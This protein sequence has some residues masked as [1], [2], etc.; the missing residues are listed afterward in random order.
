MNFT[1]LYASGSGVECSVLKNM[2]SGS[3]RIWDTVLWTSWHQEASQYGTKC[4]ELHFSTG[5]SGS[6]VE[7]CELHVITD[8]RIW[9]GV[10]WI[11]CRH[12]HQDLVW[13]NLNFTSS[14]GTRIWY[15]RLWMHVIAGHQNFVKASCSGC[16]T[17]DGCAEC[18]TVDGCGG[19]LTVGGC[20]G[21]LTIGDCGGCFTV[22]VVMLFNFWWS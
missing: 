16:L 7:Y 19:Y 15:G 3:I 13:S 4:C 11:K 9:N 21:C 2:S 5:V 20:A 10:F 17:I 22:D 6:G 1:L 8:I 18:L 12:R 14:R